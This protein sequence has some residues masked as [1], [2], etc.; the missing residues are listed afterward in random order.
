MTSLPNDPSNAAQARAAR[1][2]RGY[3]RFTSEQVGAMNQPAIMNLALQQSLQS[4]SFNDTQIWTFSRRRNDGVVDRPLA[5]YANSL[6]LRANSAYFDTRMY[7]SLKVHYREM[8]IN[9]VYSLQF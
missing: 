2:F 3:Q 7:T 8:T 4:G 1:T 5:L 6:V 9:C